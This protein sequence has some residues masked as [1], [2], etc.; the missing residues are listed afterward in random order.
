MAITAKFTLRVPDLGLDARVLVERTSSAAVDKIRESLR[1]GFDP[2]T[3]APRDR[4]GDGKPLGYNTGRL[5]EGIGITG[6]HGDANRASTK[7]VPP[8]DRVAYVEANPD[9]LTA[10]GLVGEAIQEAAEKYVR[11]RE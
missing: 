5:A 7:I 4:K 8:P 9:V 2:T 11:E 10:G 3:G 6:I 1:E